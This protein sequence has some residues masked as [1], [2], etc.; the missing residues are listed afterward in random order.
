MAY[1]EHTWE[2]G[3]I[4]TAEKL[5]H[6]ESGIGSFYVTFTVTEEGDLLSATYNDILNALNAGKTVALS[7]TD[8][9]ANYIMYLAEYGYEDGTYSVGFLNIRTLTNKYFEADDADTNLI[10]MGDSPDAD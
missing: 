6:M 3:E 10:A 2:T 8:S 9:P 5:N 4:I 1:E 7:Y